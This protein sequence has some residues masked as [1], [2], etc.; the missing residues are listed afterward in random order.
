MRGPRAAHPI[1][2][3]CQAAVVGACGSVEVTQPVHHAPVIR[4][5][6]VF[7]GVIGLTD[8]ALVRGGDGGVPRDGLAP[9][10]F[11]ALT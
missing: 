5:L 1:L 11:S 7:P 9:P 3:L 2:A 8:S 4:S 6:K 10:R